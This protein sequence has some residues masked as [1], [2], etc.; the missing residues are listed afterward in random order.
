VEVCSE[1]DPRSRPSG[2]LTVNSAREV[3]SPVAD[4]PGFMTVAVP[5]ETT[6]IS[7]GKAISQDLSAP[8]WRDCSRIRDQSLQQTSANPAS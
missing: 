1:L 8:G 5:L 2:E 6:Q 3:K 4:K 7:C